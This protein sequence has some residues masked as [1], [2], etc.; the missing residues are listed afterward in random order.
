MI[1]CPN[2]D[3]QNPVG[4]TQCE[5]CLSSLPTTTSC[6]ICGSLVQANSIFCGQC[7]FDLQ[8]KTTNL[9]HTYPTQ[10]QEPETGQNPAPQLEKVSELDS[11]T[12]I[13][14]T[15]TI[16][17]SVISA[18]LLHV[19]TDTLIELPPELKVIR[20]GKPNRK[21][22]PDIDVSG[23]PNS[24]F[25]SR[26]HAKIIRREGLFYIED[27]GSSNGTYINHTFLPLGKSHRLVPGD[28]I[29]LGKED[30]I[31]FIFQMA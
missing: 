20:L 8:Q 6:P 14:I 30:K 12:E 2:C 25:A 4:A 7:G 10:V 15:E 22:Y 5:A 24:E 28:R 11:G 16:Q 9:K 18:S 26:V 29:A 17:L 3:Y 27:L 19:Q 31:S 23:F 21:F 13:E 1:I